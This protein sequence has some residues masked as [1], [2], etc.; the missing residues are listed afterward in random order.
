MNINMNLILDVISRV[1]LV[2]LERIGLL[3]T[4][5]AIPTAVV[6]GHARVASFPDE[7][8]LFEKFGC[9]KHT[10]MVNKT[11][12]GYVELI[13]SIQVD[14]DVETEIPSELHVEAWV[15]LGCLSPH[16]ARLRPSFLSNL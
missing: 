8:R 11:P 15:A 9:E 4:G 14:T 2:S 13:E 1:L 5:K 10:D 7:Q 12:A 3:P 6:F 16:K